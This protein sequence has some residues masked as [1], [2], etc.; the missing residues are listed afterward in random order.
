MYTSPDRQVIFIHIR[1]SF[2]VATSMHT[3]CV[4]VVLRQSSHQMRYEITTGELYGSRVNIMKISVGIGR[5]STQFRGRK[6]TIG[7]C[8]NKLGLTT[9]NNKAVQMLDVQRAAEAPCWTAT[10]ATAGCVCV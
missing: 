2:E 7:Y 6:L 1:C 9:F 10:A 3:V 5:T 8:T 4:T